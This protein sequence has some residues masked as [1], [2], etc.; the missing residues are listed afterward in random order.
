[1]VIIHIFRKLNIC[2]VFYYLFLY[3]SDLKFSLSMLLNQE[4]KVIITLCNILID[5]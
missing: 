4:K 5:L 1:M 2:L 3:N